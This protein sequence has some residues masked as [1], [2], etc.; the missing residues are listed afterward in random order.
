MSKRQL[1]LH[2]V[3]CYSHLQEFLP[4]CVQ[5][6]PLLATA[7]CTFP[8]FHPSHLQHVH[9]CMFVPGCLKLSLSIMLLLW[10]INILTHNTASTTSPNNID[11]NTLTL[12]T[13][14][15]WDPRLQHLVMINIFWNLTHAYATQ[16]HGAGFNLNIPFIK[17]HDQ[18]F[19]LILT[20]SVN[21]MGTDVIIGEH[22]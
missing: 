13:S 2:L 20:L 16:E 15:D 7:R 3:K 18:H 21:E 12:G 9:W 11:I 19:Q 10:G 1:K 17:Y 5:C 4:N 22:I 6:S 8:C 14:I